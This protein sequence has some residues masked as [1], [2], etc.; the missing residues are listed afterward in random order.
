MSPITIN[1]VEDFINSI[2]PESGI[3]VDIYGYVIRIEERLNCSSH[4]GKTMF[5]HP[6]NDTLANALKDVQA[7]VADAGVKLLKN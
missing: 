2:R 6:G 7:I 1:K 3:Y 4:L 5:A